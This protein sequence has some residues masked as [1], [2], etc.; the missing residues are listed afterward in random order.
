MD[1]RKEVHNELHF[2]GSAESPW[3]IPAA[4]HQFLKGATMKTDFKGGLDRPG[5][6]AEPALGKLS[7]PDVHA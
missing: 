5:N 1:D 7:F 4:F 2:L 3:V 6:G